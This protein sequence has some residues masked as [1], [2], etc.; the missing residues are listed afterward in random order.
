M[1]S[2][3]AGENF[4]RET[5]GPGLPILESGKVEEG[6]DLAVHILCRDVVGPDRC[7]DIIEESTAAGDAALVCDVY[8][9]ENGTSTKYLS[10]L[11]GFPVSSSS[12]PRYEDRV[13]DPVFHYT[14][15]SL[16]FVIGVLVVVIYFFFLIGYLMYEAGNAAISIPTRPRVQTK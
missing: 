11:C 3:S 16:Y 7:R 4:V 10:G 6:R 1:S 2:S 14:P 9:R 13:S 12:L 8:S 5:F 15:S